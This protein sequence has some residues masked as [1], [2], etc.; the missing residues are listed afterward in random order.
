MRIESGTVV[1]IDEDRVLVESGSEVACSSCK[2]QDACLMDKDSHKR[3]IWVVNSLGVQNGETVS[4]MI[5]EKGVLLAAV[6]LYLLPII[7]LMAGAA[8]LSLAAPSF[9]YDKDLFAVIGGFAGLI[10]YAL[11]L[12]IV[13]PKIKNK[14]IFS[15]SLVSKEQQISS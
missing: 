6:I 9:G 12:K 2:M 1:A 14:K 4:Y 5:E 15:P 11:A 13:Y 8:T 10:V 3:R 7:L